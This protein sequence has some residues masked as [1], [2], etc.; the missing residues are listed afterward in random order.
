MPELHG[1][2][3]YVHYAHVAAT[4]YPRA[5]S[6]LGIDIGLAPLR[7]TALNRAKS[8]IKYL[9]YSATG[10]ATIA[11]PVAPY[12]DS[13]NENRGV[14]VSANTPEAWSV[15]MRRLV[16]EPQ[17]RQYVA[18]N[19]YE[20]VHRERSIECTAHKWLTVFRDYADIST[21]REP[22]GDDSLDG[23][24]L[25]RATANIVLRQLPHDVQQ[26]RMASTAVNISRRISVRHGTVST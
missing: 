9:E 25:R 11:S 24:H 18:T 21:A 2:R 10:A 20:W 13:V 5:L 6:D 17:L 14:L 1:L 23:R 26:V 15:A 7:D 8:D 19:A 22:R 16:E 3:D 4:A 12:L